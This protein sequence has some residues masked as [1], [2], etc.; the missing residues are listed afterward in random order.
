MQRGTGRQGYTSVCAVC[1]MSGRAYGGICMIASLLKKDNSG[2]LQERHSCD[3]D[4][5]WQV[6][7]MRENSVKQ[8]VL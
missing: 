8:P 1:S 5:T 2:K 3:M 6:I 7:T 4:R